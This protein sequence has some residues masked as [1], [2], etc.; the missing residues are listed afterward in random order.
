MEKQNQELELYIHIPFCVRKCLYCDFVSFAGKEAEQ[1]RYV[2]ALLNEIKSYATL[3]GECHVSSVY[4]GGGTPTV[5]ET[6]QLLAVI[7]TLVKSF[8]VTGTKEKRRGWHAQKLKRPETEFTIECNPG[9]VDLKKLKCLKKAGVNRISFGLQSADDGELKALGRIHTFADFMDSFEA[10]RDAGFD[11]INVDLMQAIPHQTLAGWLKTLSVVSSLG[12]EHIS[13][14]SLIVEEG[15]P[16]YE[17]QQAGNLPLPDEDC[18][19]EIYYTTRDFLG[20]AGYIRY[21]ISNYAKPGFACRHNAGYWKRTSYLGLGLNASSLYRETRWKNTA[22]LR[23]Y[24]DA[25]SDPEKAGQIASALM[26]AVKAKREFAERYEEK[27]SGASEEEAVICDFHRLRHKEKMEEFMFLGLRMTDGISKQ[28]FFDTFGQDFD[29]TYGLVAEELKAKGLLQVN[30][31]RVF[32]TDRG[33][34]VSNTVLAEF[35]LDE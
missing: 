34:D 33:I 23:A 27:Q 6:E 25:Y 17:R 18:E 13:A 1:A 2:D 16:F 29:F 9:T 7:E 4:I 11:N 14:Y 10:A 20:K 22:D 26:D 35:L 31:D 5:L 30:G 3:F 19:R 15:T 8:S 32:L 12:P 28:A 21:E 24:M